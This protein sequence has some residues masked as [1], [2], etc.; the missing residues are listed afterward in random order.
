MRA[1]ALGLTP[2]ERITITQSWL[3]RWPHPSG[4]VFLAT[5]GDGRGAAQAGILR[6]MSAPAP[7]VP[8]ASGAGSRP[9]PRPVA[10]AVLL[11][12]AVALGANHVA[13]RLA[14]DHGANVATAVVLRSLGTAVAIGLLLRA[15]GVPMRL[16]PPTARR[17]IVVG[18]GVATQSLCLYSAVARLPVALAL[19]VFNTFPLLLAL[20]TWRIDGQRPDARVLIAMLIAL[21]GLTLALDVPGRLAGARAAGQPLPMAGVAF[22]F[23][24]AVAFSTALF[25]TTRWLGGVDGRVRTLWTMGVVLTVAVVVG[26]S[27]IG[28]ALPVDATGWVGLGLLTVLYGAAITG[29]FVLLPRLGAVNNAALLNFEPIAAMALGWLVLD[30]RMAPVQ[31]AGA[32]IVVVAIVMLSTG[33]R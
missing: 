15:T 16:P 5:G 20:I 9:I 29:V 33:R 4:R 3:T 28:F 22:A 25:L 18:L 8:T 27:T 14:F 30:Q 24:A 19:L 6:G 17:A 23:A 11:L 26:G 1:T 10:V 2:P 13:A 21:V 32:L 7:T 31:V 12:I